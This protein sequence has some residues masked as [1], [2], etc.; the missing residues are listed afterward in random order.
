MNVCK[1][2]KMIEK[3][4]QINSGYIMTVG[5]PLVPLL[6]STD[7]GAVQKILYTIISDY[8]STEMFLG[9]VV[10]IFLH[11][12]QKNL[13]DDIVQVR[14]PNNLH[15]ILVP[16]LSNLKWK[17]V[18]VQTNEQFGKDQSLEK[19]CISLATLLLENK[20]VKKMRGDLPKFADYI[21]TLDPLS[22]IC[23]RFEKSAFM[24]CARLQA[25]EDNDG[26]PVR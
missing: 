4:L 2:L 22:A 18:L 8:G 25:I 5:A 12:E 17:K 23:D 19:A 11:Y 9:P 6:E 7:V 13:S 14:Q 21:K 16:Y 24:A 3:E 1:G 15:R 20:T 10:K 26:Y